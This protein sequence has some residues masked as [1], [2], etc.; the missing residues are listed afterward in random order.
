MKPTQ[1]EIQ[2]RVKLLA[3]K[4]RSVKCKAQDPPESSLPTQGKAPK[5]GVLV[6]RSSV[7][8]RGSHAKVRV[9]GKALPSLDEVYE[10]A[11]VQRRSSSTF[12]AKGSSRKVVEPP[13]K[14][15]PIYV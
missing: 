3:K 8:E 13:L 9:R 7:E 6:L 14:V 4:K 12:G 10:E 5:L 11:G 2:V 15:L 1:G